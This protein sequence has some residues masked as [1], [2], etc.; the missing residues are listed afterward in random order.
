MLNGRRG[1]YKW[2][3][4]DKRESPMGRSFVS[5]NTLSSHPLGGSGQGAKVYKCTNERKTTHV[6]PRGR[7]YPPA[8]VAPLPGTC[9]NRIQ[10]F[11]RGNFT[12][13][14]FDVLC[15]RATL[16][17]LIAV[18]AVTV[19]A[20]IHPKHRTQDTSTERSRLSMCSTLI[21]APRHGGGAESMAK[22]GGILPWRGLHLFKLCWRGTLD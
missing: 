22:P 6:F 21:T 13:F 19:T 12:P 14:A 4:T 18:T 10:G 8:S 1:H 2:A 3:N 20:S 16:F 11:F 15:N 7:D 9:E 17:I 5:L